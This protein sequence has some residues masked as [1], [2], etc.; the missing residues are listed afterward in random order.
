MSLV[1]G[2]DEF[3]LEGK[4]D[5]LTGRISAAVMRKI[6]ETN[7]G[8][9]DFEGVKVIY[10][11]GDDVPS[12]NDLIE[13]EAYLE[14]DLFVDPVS[15]IDVKVCISI[16]RDE[17]PEYQGEFVLDGETGWIIPK[18]NV[19][20]FVEKLLLLI[21]DENERSRLSKNG[22]IFVKT[23]FHYSTLVKNMDEYYQL[24]LKKKKNK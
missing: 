14:L 1:K 21:E 11:P 18:N 5:S 20:L 4:Y 24:L 22:W 15:N 2:F 16:I 17:A 10:G 3:L 13:D 7:T 19:T 12:F 8:E 9:E 6:K 23:K